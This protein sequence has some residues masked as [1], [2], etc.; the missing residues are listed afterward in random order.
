MEQI[1][2]ILEAKEYITKM[3][4]VQPELGLILGSGLGDLA[5]EIKNPFTIPYADIPNFPISTVAGHAGELIIGALEGKIVMA[6][7]GRFHYYEGYSIQ[8]IILPVRVMKTLGVKTLIVTNACGGMNPDFHA[9]DL[10]LITDH[11]NFMWSNPLIGPNLD[12]FGSRFPDISRAYTKELLDLGKQVAS[13]LGIEVRSG[14]YCGISGPSFMT[15]SELRMLR[16]WGA[17]AV[18]MSTIP[19]V[20]AAAHMSMDVLG[21]SCVTDM[22]IADELEPINHNIVMNMAKQAKPKFTKLLK[23]IIKEMYLK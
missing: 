2:A 8:D 21:V 16:Q 23:G 4:N 19:E 6:M 1:K 5:D 18:G 12:E 9:G 13:N 20:I 3:V 10:M 15:R 22:A 17:D 7:K 11:I 14:V